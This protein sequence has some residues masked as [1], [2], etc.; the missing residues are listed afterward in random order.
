ML[1]LFDFIDQ[2]IT[3]CGQSVLIWKSGWIT[4]SSHMHRVTAKSPTIDPM[5]KQDVSIVAIVVPTLE[6]LVIFKIV[7]KFKQYVNTIGIVVNEE[8]R[9]VSEVNIRSDKG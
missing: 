1:A 6:V 9:P 2:Y 3:K 5:V 7:L 4:E 8:A